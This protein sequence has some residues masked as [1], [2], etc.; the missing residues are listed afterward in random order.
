MG[1]GTA[2]D[3]IPENNLQAFFLSLHHMCL[4]ILV[5]GFFYTLSV[6]SPHISKGITSPHNK[7]LS[8][9]NKNDVAKVQ[10]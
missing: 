7:S 4:R 6:P 10:P 9:H 5:T 2:P 8:S 1:G 3:W